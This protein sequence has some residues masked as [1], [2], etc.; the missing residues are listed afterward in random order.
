MPDNDDND[1][2]YVTR[3]F[4]DERFLRVMEKLDN[5]GSKIDRQSESRFSA[6]EKALVVVATLG[7]IGTTI[8]ALLIY[9]KP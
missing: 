1:P 7:L 4:C 3:D 6:K 5:I 8:T 9:L 2:G